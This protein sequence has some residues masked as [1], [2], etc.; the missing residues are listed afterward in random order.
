MLDEKGD[1]GPF[2]DITSTYDKVRKQPVLKIDTI[3]KK[4]DP[5]FHALLPGGHEHFLLM[6]LPRESVMKREIGK[7]AHVKDVR[8]THGGCSW[9][10]GVVSIKKDDH[11]DIDQVITKAF[12]AHTSMKKVIIV[13][14]DIDI[15]DDRQVEWAVA[16][17]FQPHKDLTILEDQKG[18]SLD[19]S[20]PDL[21]SKWALD[22]TRPWE[23]EEF[24]RAKLE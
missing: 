11:T 8:L 5:I 10:H 24:E 18:S 20:A 19:P 23:G 4:Q 9:L 13:D 3:W 17:R 12:Q 15:Y 7:I 22:A 16:T 14:D 21:T 1:E 2:V 6:G